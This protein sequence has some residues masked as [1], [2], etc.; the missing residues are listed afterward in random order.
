[1]V[2]PHDSHYHLIMIDNNI[3]TDSLFDEV[4]AIANTIAPIG[5]HQFSPVLH[6]I[7][8]S[9]RSAGEMII[10]RGESNPGEIFILEG[11]VRT[12]L[13][14]SE[15]REVTLNIHVGPCTYTPSI[16]RE[17]D[18]ISRIDCESLTR[19]RIAR[20]ST[21]N[22]IECMMKNTEVQ[23]W[24]DAVLRGEL[25]VRADREW[26]LAALPGLERLQQFRLR[27]PELEAHIPH[28]HIASFLGLTPVTLSRLRSQLDETKA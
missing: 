25:V 4:L 17:I 20:F 13:S 15:G 1:V 19:V 6:D 7:K 10:R 5:Y 18:S 23:R 24:G 14:D 22:L 27:Y 28:Y 16:G 2:N 8:F 21:D 11:I 26:V 9:T 3:S 12:F